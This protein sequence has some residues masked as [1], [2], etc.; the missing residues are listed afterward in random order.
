MN[1]TNFSTR[2]YLKEIDTALF[3]STRNNLK[4][5]INANLIEITK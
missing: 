4:E 5:R 2:Y 1:D 3:K